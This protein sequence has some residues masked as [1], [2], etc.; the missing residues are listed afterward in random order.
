MNAFEE[1]GRTGGKAPAAAKTAQDKAGEGVGLVSDKAA[2]VAGTAKDQATQV[3]EEATSQAR[4]LA[5]EVRDQLRA[6]AGA[7]TQN[8]AATVRRL[9][10]ELKQMSDGADTDSTAVA[11]VRQTANAGH[12][13][14]SRLEERG[15]D[16][17]LGDLRDFARR[18]PGVFLAGA[19]LAGFA[20]ARAGKGISAAGSS[21]AP[22]EG[23]ER[24]RPGALPAASPGPP[25]SSAP[26]GTPARAVYE[27]P[28]DT[29]GQSQPPHVTPAGQ[30][31]SAA[32][33]AP[34]PATSPTAPPVR[35][36]PWRTV[37]GD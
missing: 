1:T 4:D 36:E 34:G 12:R 6:Q 35:S 25:L 16:G 18:K 2:G 33:A 10:D 21:G 31:G 32:P 37:E 19:A 11:A 20:V 28:L 23:D 17:L 7:Q 13:V 5:G 26:G 22:P 9:A 30:R 15:P 3:A 27:D 14:A 8:V 29:Y 24:A